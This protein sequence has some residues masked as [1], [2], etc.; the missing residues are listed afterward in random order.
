[1]VTEYAWAASSC[2]PCPSPPLRPQDFMALGGDVISGV[3]LSSSTLTRLHARYGKDALG[4]DLVF[5]KADP[6]VGGR[7][8]MM[9]G[10]KLETGSRTGG[11]NN[12]QGRYAIR[13]PW[14]GEIDCKNP[15]RGIWGGPPN[16]GRPEAKPALDLAFAPRGETKLASLVTHDVAEI[17]LKADTALV[18]HPGM[19]PTTAK[20]KK[21]PKDAKADAKATKD[22]APPKEK[23]GC[24][25]P[26][27]P[28]DDRGWPW[29]ALGLGLI[30]TW[31]RRR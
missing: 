19:V 16:G 28:E 17:E 20:E 24:R 8:F 27:A 1:V 5:K 22:A 7:E 2:D 4:E 21:S 18:E 25:V 12:F 3:Q 10:K 30:A 29:A 6:I 26:G 31:R 15:R 14:E 11:R 9:K 13:H 23:C